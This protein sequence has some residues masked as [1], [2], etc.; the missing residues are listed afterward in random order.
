MN[1]KGE[2]QP[3]LILVIGGSIY[4]YWKN[5]ED[6]KEVI[7]GKLAKYF[8]QPEMLKPIVFHTS[9]WEEI[10]SIGGAPASAYSPGTLSQI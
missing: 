1:H 9:A 10:R 2:I 5:R 8:K 3:A 6:L 7:V 4:R